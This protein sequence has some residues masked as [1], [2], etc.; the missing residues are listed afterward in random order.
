MFEFF[1]EMYWKMA[2]AVTGQ[3]SD[4]ELGVKLRRITEASTHIEAERN[5]QQICLV[6]FTTPGVKPICIKNLS[7][8]DCVSYGTALGGTGQTYPTG[9]CPPNSRPFPS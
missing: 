3:I 5:A 6:N 2:R 4:D 7:P 8:E 1:R 9:T